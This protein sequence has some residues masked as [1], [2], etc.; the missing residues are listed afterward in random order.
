MKSCLNVTF[1]VSNSSD[2]RFF[3]KSETEKLIQ[4]S[5]RMSNLASVH[6]QWFVNNL[7]VY[8][9]DLKN[10][11]KIMMDSANHLEKEGEQLM[12]DY[13]SEIGKLKKSISERVY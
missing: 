9:K 3:S 8:G 6:T 12:K 4:I 1:P 7:H 13:L 5:E 10:D 2:F 11:K